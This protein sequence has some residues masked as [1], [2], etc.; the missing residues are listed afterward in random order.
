MKQ[1]KNIKRGKKARKGGQKFETKVRNNLEEK[2]W[3][4]IKNP[5][6]VID[7]KFVQGKPKYNPFTKKLMM[8]SGGFPDFVCFSKFGWEY[9]WM[10]PT[11]K[12]NYKKY[13]G[14]V[15]TNI[16]GVESKIRGYLDKEEKEKAKWLLKNKIFSKILIAKKS[17]QGR[18]VVVEYKEFK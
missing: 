14:K 9:E 12:L 6:N 1:E 8:A 18:R 15:T 4:V 13:S 2:G 11:H 17:K 5:N 7:N 3:I 16:I 10:Y